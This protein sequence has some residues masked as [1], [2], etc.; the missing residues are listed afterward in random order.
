MEEATTDL[1]VEEAVHA[2]SGN[3]VELLFLI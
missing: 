3:I 1:T 2:A